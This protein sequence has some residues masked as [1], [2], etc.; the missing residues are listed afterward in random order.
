[1]AGEPMRNIGDLV[2]GDEAI[3]LCEA[4]FAVPVIEEPAKRTAT[5]KS[6]AEQRG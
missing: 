1:M 3:R 2:E 6:A 4:G 5:K